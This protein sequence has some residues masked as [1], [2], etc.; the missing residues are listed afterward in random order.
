MDWGPRVPNG[1]TSG[2]GNIEECGD[3]EEPIDRDWRCF[4]LA[5]PVIR[6]KQRPIDQPIAGGIDPVSKGS[7]LGVG[8]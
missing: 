2:C 1:A 5:Q 7:L 4:S 3:I 6:A 8:L